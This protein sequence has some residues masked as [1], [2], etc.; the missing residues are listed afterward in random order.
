VFV[1]GKD[2]ERYV[3]SGRSQHVDLMPALHAASQHLEKYGGHPQACGLSIC[4]FDAFERATSIIRH[5]IES[6]MIEA[7]SSPTCAVDSEIDLQDVDWALVEGVEKC[8]PFG[9]GNPSPLFVAK[10]VAV[11][12]LST[13]GADGKHLRLTVQ[14]PRGNM[15]KMIGFSFGFY[16][17]SLRLGDVIDVAFEVSVN[18]WNGNRELQG[19]IVDIRVVES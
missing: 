10:S 4:G 12:G 2:G 19:R 13:V 6:S 17:K 18:E 15:L 8:K 16:I 11:V 7:D 9:M 3:G 5:T 14:S 1:F